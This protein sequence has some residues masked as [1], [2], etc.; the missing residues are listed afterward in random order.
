MQS[1]VSTPHLLLQ[2]LR[3][4]LKYL[5]SSRELTPPQSS[6]VI[7]THSL[8]PLSPTIYRSITFATRTSA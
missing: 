8:V 3:F 7:P 5:N 1:A 6:R 2:S 4:S